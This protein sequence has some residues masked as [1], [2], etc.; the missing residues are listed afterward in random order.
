MLADDLKREIESYSASLRANN[1][2]FARA[3]AGTL[4]RAQVARYIANIHFLVKGTPPCL[5]RARDRA[6]QRGMADLARH[7]DRKLHEETGHHLWAEQDLTRLGDEVDADLAERAVPALRD[8]FA[9]L[10]AAIDRDPMLYL[11]YTVLAEYMTVLVGGDWIEM[12]EQRCGIPREALSVIG[13]HVELDREHAV[14]GLSEVDALT[15]EAKYLEPMRQ[16][17][18]DAFHY[19]DRMCAEVVDA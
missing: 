10:T 1:E 5:A 17:L 7:F 11:Y 9:Y 3:A 2:M 18:A 12:V 16:L 8:L 13:N 6:M 14:D 15:P 19:L 4:T